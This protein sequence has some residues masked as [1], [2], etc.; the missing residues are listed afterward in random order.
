MMSGTHIVTT[1]CPTTSDVRRTRSNFSSKIIA[2]ASWQVIV[3]EDSSW[4]ALVH[5]QMMH[6]ITI[7]RI[8]DRLVLNE[9]LL[10]GDVN[11]H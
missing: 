2:Q 3:V 9:D 1:Y 7:G 11:V 5:E 6:E 4:I 8:N 10:P